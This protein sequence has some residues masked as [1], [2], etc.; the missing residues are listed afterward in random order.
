MNDQRSERTSLPEEMRHQPAVHDVPKDF[1]ARPPLQLHEIEILGNVDI[2]VDESIR[3]VGLIKLH[4][5]RL[6]QVSMAAYSFTI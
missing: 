4:Q 2:A 5:L 6:F 1:F 3:R